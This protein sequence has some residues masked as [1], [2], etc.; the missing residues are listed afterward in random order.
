MTDLLPPATYD[1][2]YPTGNGHESLSGTPPE[3][4]ATVPPADEKPPEPRTEP[5]TIAYAATIL[6]RLTEAVRTHGVVGEDAT[7]RASYLATTS[8]LLDKPVS[9]AVKGHSASGKSYTVQTTLKFFPEGA[10]IAMTGMSE[11]ALIFDERDFK[12]R[13]IVM[14]EAEGLRESNDDNGTA[15]YVRSL[16]SEG[17]L[18]YPCT[19]PD[20]KNGG[21]TTKE[22]RKDGPT[23]LIFTTTRT[24]VH[25]ENETRVLSLTTNDSPDQTRAV[26]RVL[27]AEDRTGVDLS[28]WHELQRWLEKHGEKRVTIPYAGRLANKV[29]PVAV[30]LRRDFSAVLS[31][32]QAHAVLHQANRDRNDAGKIVASFEDYEVVRDLVKDVLAEG[33]GS[34]ASKT[35]RETV[36]AVRA[37]T[38]DRH[39]TGVTAQTLAKELKLDKSAARRRLLT[40]SD[41]DY[42]HNLED[43]KGQPGRWVVGEPL[44]DEQI[45]LPAVDVLLAGGNGTATGDPLSLQGKTAPGGTVAVDPGG[46]PDAWL[47]RAISDINPDDPEHGVKVARIRGEAAQRRKDAEASRL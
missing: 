2:L 15:Y 22:Y 3:T 31:L 35:L 47:K 17:E 21:F 14:Y 20:K 44:P 11:R 41:G 4:V 34:S 33:V 42:V 29:P 36:E 38:A 26:L 45:V 1:D 25:G 28:E 8:R 12:H 9:L 16:L 40:A 27:A 6:D 7:V 18:R 32:I 13:T 10:V 39:K 23:N 19:I 30:R 5:P 43:R 46:S 37:L 24:Q